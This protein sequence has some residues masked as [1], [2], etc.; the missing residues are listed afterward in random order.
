LKTAAF[1]VLRVV[2]MA[3]VVLMGLRVLRELALASSGDTAIPIIVGIPVVAAV[4]YWGYRVI[5]LPIP[6]RRQRS[7]EH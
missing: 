4:V 3:F 5:W 6:R 7:R 2:G 1:W